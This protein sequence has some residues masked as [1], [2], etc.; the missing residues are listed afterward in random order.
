MYLNDILYLNNKLKY[1][2]HVY[3]VLLQL[4]KTGL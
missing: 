1:K 3:K 2:K 4:Y